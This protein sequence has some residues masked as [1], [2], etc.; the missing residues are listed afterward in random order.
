MVGR[1]AGRAAAVVG[2]EV[3]E[4]VVMTREDVEAACAPAPDSQ[5]ARL[6][7]EGVAH[8]ID[9]YA[10]TGKAGAS[11]H[12]PLALVA[13]LDDSV[14]DWAATRVEVELEGHW[15]RGETVTDLRGIRRTPW[16]GWE[17]EENARGGHLGGR[18]GGHAADRGTAGV[19]GRGARVSPT[20]AVVG[21]IN[22]DLVARVL[23]LPGPGETVTGGEFARHH[24][25]KGGNQATAAARALRGRTPTVDH[26]RRGGRRRLGARRRR[27]SR[28]RASCCRCGR[29]T[30]RPGVA[31]IVVDSSGENQIAVA[32]GANVAFGGQQVHGALERSPTRRGAGEPRGLARRGDA[33][34]PGTARRP[35]RPSC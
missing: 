19:A 22:V 21:A 13:L 35:A 34:P 23:M 5:L 6:I 1:G 29:S 27:R 28:P 26:D 20:L 25:G 32:P 7:R 14:C 4:Q 30:R 31:L 8:Y 16:S 15:T 18:P 3:T 10:S 17:V 2:L 12:D 24:G 9:F 33:R 11:M